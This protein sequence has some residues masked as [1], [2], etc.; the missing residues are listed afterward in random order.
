MSVRPLVVPSLGPSVGP[1]VTFSL[2][3]LLGATYGRVSGL[4]YI[5]LP[6]ARIKCE[7][8]LSFSLRFVLASQY[9]GDSV[10][11]SPLEWSVTCLFKCRQLMVFSVNIIGAVEL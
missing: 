1:L 4:V 8:F 11:P 9:E 5:R 6:S 10:R 7:G 3:G 2:F